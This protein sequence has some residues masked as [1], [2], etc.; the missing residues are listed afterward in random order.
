MLLNLLDSNPSTV[1]KEYFVYL[2][3][4][5]YSEPTKLPDGR[6]FVRISDKN[7]RIFEQINRA[8]V[9]TDNCFKV[10]AQAQLKKYDDIII[11]QAVTSSESW[12]SKKLDESFLRGVYESSV[13]DDGILEAPFAKIKGSVV[14][15]AFDTEKERVN[16]STS[17]VPGSSWDIVIELVGIWFLK[18]TFGPVWRVIQLRH[19][20]NRAATVV[21][22]DYMFSDE[23]EDPGHQEDDYEDI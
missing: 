6:Y 16:L 5:E 9:S 17:V 13:S 22:K 23:S 7:G 14:A 15:I 19:S 10:H 4:M 3:E 12:F 8:E 21:P 1:I 11:Q 20:K 2:V 18:K